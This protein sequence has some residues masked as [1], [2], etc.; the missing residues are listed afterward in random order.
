FQLEEC[1]QRNATDGTKIYL[2]P[3]KPQAIVRVVL[4]AR[5]SRQTAAFVERELSK[6]HF[7]HVALEQARLHKDYFEVEVRSFSLRELKEQLVGTARPSNAVLPNL[8][9]DDD[10]LSV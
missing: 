4:G 7:A 8:Y 6:P 3:I 10:S 1:K 2:Y 5:I 9:D